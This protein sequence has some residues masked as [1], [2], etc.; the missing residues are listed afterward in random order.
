[1]KKEPVRVG[2]KYRTIAGGWEVVKTRPGGIVEL[3]NK[4]KSLFVDV[5]TRQL[6][7]WQKEK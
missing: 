1:M 2:D 4:E 3:F 6:V 5:Y 7:F